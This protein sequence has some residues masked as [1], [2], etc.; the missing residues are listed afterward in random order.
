MIAV[1]LE[2][3]GFG[4]ELSAAVFSEVV[5]IFACGGAAGV[6]IFAAAAGFGAGLVHTFSSFAEIHPQR[7]LQSFGHWAQHS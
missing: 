7:A 6:A 1:P 5:E 3:D 4:F 2:G